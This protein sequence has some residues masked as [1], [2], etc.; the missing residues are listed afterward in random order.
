MTDLE[1]RV[2]SI[3]KRLSALEVEVQKRTNLSADAIRESIGKSIRES[4]GDLSKES[5]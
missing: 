1:K 5:A 3:E 2:E 4:L